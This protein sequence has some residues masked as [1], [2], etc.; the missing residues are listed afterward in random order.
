MTCNN[1][2]SWVNRAK[3]KLTLHKLIFHDTAPR[4]CILTVLL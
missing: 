4:V 2:M 3:V 1:N